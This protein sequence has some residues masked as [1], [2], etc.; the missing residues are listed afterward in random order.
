[1]KI[2]SL[3]SGIGAFE[4]AIQR[5]G[6]DFELVNYCEIDKY[7]S[8]AYSAIHGV[9]ESLNL[10]DI[11]KVDEKALP[12]DL[13]LVCYGFPCQDISQAGKQKGLFNEDGTQTRSGLFFEALRIIEETQPRVAIAENVKALTSKKFEKE[14]S[15]VLKSLEEAG[16]NNYWQIMN[17]KN[18]GIPQNRERVFIVSIRKDIDTGMF[19]F[20][21][22]F[23]LK[24][25]LKD[26]C[27]LVVDEKYYL[28]DANIKKI[29]H[30][31]FAQEATRIQKDDVCQTLLARD[32][33]DAKCIEVERIGNNGEQIISHIN[34]E[35]EEEKDSPVRLGNIYGDNFGYGFGGN[36]WGKNGVAPT[37]KTT[38]AASQ[39]FIFSEDNPRMHK[40]FDIPKEILNDNRNQR[41]VW[42]TDGIAPTLLARPD[43][44]K[45]LVRNEQNDSMIAE[46]IIVDDTYANREARL[47]S[48]YAPTLRSDRSGLKVIEPNVLTQKRT[49]YGKEIRKAYESGEVKEK[50]GNMK[51]M[52]PR[53]D[54]IANTL[55]TL[56]K[57]NL[58]VEPTEA[59][60]VGNTSPS[61]HSQCNDVYSTEGIYPT[62]CAGT[63]GN[64]NP[65]IVESNSLRIRKLT[66][67]EYFR[68]QDFDDS[69]FAKAEKVCSNTQLYK[70]A[71]NSITV[72]CPYYLIKALFD[73]N[74]YKKSEVKEMELKIKEVT[75][76]EII[77]FNFD[78]LKEEITT[79]VAL[80]KNLVYSEEQIKEAKEDRANLNKFVKALSDERIKIK[81]QCLQPYESFEAKVNE[82][83]K[84]VQEPIALIDSQV[85]A[86]EDKQKLEKRNQI[87]TYFMGVDHSKWLTLEQIWNEKWLN[88]SVSIKSVMDEI[89]ARLEQIAEH[90]NT[91]SI[92]P[93]FSFEATE[94]YKS[95]LD[96]NRAISEAKR[97]SEMA[98]AKAEHE[99]ELA[100]QKAE[101]EAKAQEEQLSGQESFCD[102][103]SFD[104]CMNPPTDPVNECDNKEWISFAALL[105]TEDALALK[106]FFNSRN[107]VFKAV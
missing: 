88:A 65:S 63:H 101:A 1:M 44:P 55:T 69:D 71:G 16:Y 50:W 100:R 79:R 2:L 72:A 102:K 8:K 70:Q 98:K 39:Q 74:I 78:E 32:Y 23:P 35:T 82:L 83:S 86:Y 91:L 51:E 43:G 66:P 96:I 34:P 95:T 54:G 4:K 87:V 6:I 107:I 73:A 76:P 36:V 81:K 29:N 22:T 10:G 94:V 68:L 60:K 93:E 77:E 92:L 49:E 75:F 17:S 15:I 52:V 61:G 14:F 9:P 24:L 58:L 30:S 80:Y 104:K 12:K 42:E 53:T 11:T 48:E 97:M 26:L 13:D 99:A 7:A 20:P 31:Q 47:Y 106:E 84:I 27:D 28:S 56:T 40:A 64:C 38:S 19:A 89:N 3:F 37:L 85:K 105:S 5:L 25:R 103:D 41:C 46:P 90:L 67:K 33:K 62:I 18:Y 59:I 21:E 57:D 45:I